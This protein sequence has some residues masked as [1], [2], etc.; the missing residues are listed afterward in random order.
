[1][2]PSFC[3]IDPKYQRENIPKGAASLH[4]RAAFRYREKHAVIRDRS[5][6]P[7]SVLSSRKFSSP[8]LHHTVSLSGRGCH[9][10]RIGGPSTQ[11]EVVVDKR[12][13]A[14]AFKRAPGGEAASMEHA[15]EN[16]TTPSAK[17]GGSHEG[18][19]AAALC[20]GLGTAMHGGE[21]PRR[22]LPHQG[23]WSLWRGQGWWSLWRS[24]ASALDGRASSGPQSAAGEQH[25]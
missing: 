8:R 13:E 21:I 19:A 10:A 25:D 9:R 18:R 20:A 22:V 5:S 24:G 16:A 23:W 14:A 2:S 3:R 1:M 6:Y 15:S 4:S 12:G 17:Q 11:Q 7:L